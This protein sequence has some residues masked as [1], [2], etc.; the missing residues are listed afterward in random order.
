MMEIKR[1]V[2][3]IEVPRPAWLEETIMKIKRM[4]LRKRVFKPVAI[5]CSML[6]IGTIGLFADVPTDNLIAY[7]P[8]NGNANDESG[9][10]YH[11][12]VYGAALT[13]DRFGNMNSAY[14]FQSKYDYISVNYPA[15]KLLN[16]SFTISAWVKIASYPGSYG[17]FIRRG[18]HANYILGVYG[19][20]VGFSYSSNP[21]PLYIPNMVI[22]DTTINLN[23]WTLVTGVYDRDLGITKL[24]VNGILD[25]FNPNAQDP[26]NPWEN[27]PLEIGNWYGTRNWW[28]YTAFTGDL[29]DIL[30]YKRALTDEEILGLY[31]QVIEAVVDI[32]PG[33]INLKSKGKWVTGYIEF[34]GDYLAED[35]DIDTVAIAK[36]NENPIDPLNRD[37][38]ADIGDHDL[39]DIPD[40]MVK[41]DRQAL[42]ALFKNRDAKDGDEIALTVSGKLTGGESFEGTCTITVINKGK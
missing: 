31:T 34:P 19:N 2:K 14:S 17:Q 28:N 3:P 8:F 30:I 18:N 21:P 10:N 15:I 41:F 36:I 33:K 22:S 12:V 25:G 39:D 20:N 7:Y 27:P 1:N 29:D 4:F 38:P 40:L 35:V 11:G 23:E 24:Y 37:G 13:T 16:T 5:I 32:E 6:L 9:N 26:H 42:I